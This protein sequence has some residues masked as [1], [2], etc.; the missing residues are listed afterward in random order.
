LDKEKQTALVEDFEETH[1]FP[2]HHQPASWKE[3]EI[4]DTAHLPAIH[5]FIAFEALGNAGGTALMLFVRRAREGF[6]AWFERECIEAERGETAATPAY[7]LGPV[8]A[9][10][11]LTVQEEFDREAAKAP[12]AAQQILHWAHRLKIR[13][14]DLR[15]T[16]VVL[17]SILIVHLA[18]TLPRNR[19]ADARVAEAALN[20]QQGRYTDAMRICRRY[21]NNTLSLLLRA[22][23]LM[24]A[25]RPD[26]AEGLYRQVLTQET[27]SPSALFGLALAL[28]RNGKF[29]E[30]EKRYADFIDIHETRQPKAAELADEFIQ[31]CREKFGKP[32]GWRKVYALPMMNDLGL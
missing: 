27:E 30:A 18:Y 5:Q 22:N 32:P 7:A 16:A 21:P 20:Y 31:L 8:T 29:K 14:T 26:Q 1:G 24:I 10:L 23:M 25:E 15:I 13:K 4:D 19:D 6:S 11:I 9:A 28:Q 3:E 17:L 2:G 12:S